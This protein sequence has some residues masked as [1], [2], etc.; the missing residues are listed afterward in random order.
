M[1]LCSINWIAAHACCDDFSEG[2]V[3]DPARQSAI[4]GAWRTTKPETDDHAHKTGESDT[5]HASVV[6]MPTP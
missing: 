1:E 3:G 5:A 2:R 6:A 4:R